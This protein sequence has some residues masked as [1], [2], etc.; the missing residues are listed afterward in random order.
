MH[1]LKV[2]TIVNTF[3]ITGELKIDSCTDFPELRFA[4]DSKLFIKKENRYI[5]VH[6]ASMREHHGFFLVRFKGLE[7]INLVEI[8][9]GCDLFVSEEDLQ[10]LPKG[11]YYYFELEGCRV[12]QN[13]QMIGT[14]TSV[15][16][17]HQAILRIAT[18]TKE[19]LVPYVPAFIKN[20]DVANKRIDVNLI[21]GFL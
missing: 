19:V 11:H 20:V 13:D 9:K 10:V 17:G 8:Y 15:D 14:V 5:E 1:Y 12:Y 2:G 16:S 3:G 21:K 7:N 4:E 18:D 6:V